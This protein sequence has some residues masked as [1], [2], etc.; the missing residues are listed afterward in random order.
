MNKAGIHVWEV[1]EITLQAEKEYTNCYTEVIVWVDLEGPGFGKQVFGYWD[2]GN[3]FKIRVTATAPGLWSYT[4]GSNADDPGL[5]G[6]MG[7]FTAQA[8]TEDE[9]LENPTRRGIVIP[10]ENGHALQ[11]S[12][13][14][15]FVMVGDTWWA[16]A[17]Y[18]YRWE[19]DEIERTGAEMSMKDMARHRRAQGFNTFGM[20]A[21]FP[22]WAN[23]G[24]STMIKIDDKHQTNIRAAWPQGDIFRDLSGKKGGSIG[25]TAMPLIS[26]KDMHNSGGRPFLFPGNIVGY[27][28]IVPDYDRINPEY[29]KE[30]DKKI[31]WLNANGFTIFIEATRR[32]CT[33]L[34]KNYCDWPMVYTRFIQYIFARYQANNCMFSPIHFDVKSASLDSRDFNEPANLFIDIYGHPPFGTTMGTNAPGSTRIAYGGPDEQRWLTCEQIGNLREHEYF[35]YLTDIFN[36]EPARPAINGEPYYS[37]HICITLDEEDNFKNVLVGDVYHEDD[38][39]NSRSS[40]FGSAL[41]GAFGGV[42]AAFEGMWSGNV[43]EVEGPYKV[44]ETMDFP[45]CSQVRYF[46]DFLLSEGSKYRDLIPNSELVT[47]NKNGDHLGWR[48]WAFCAASKHRDLIMGF[49]EKG[50]KKLKVRCLRPYDKY[51]FAWFNPRTGEWLDSIELMVTRIGNIIVPDYPDDLD[52]AFKLVKTY[53]GQPSDDVVMRESSGWQAWKIRKITDNQ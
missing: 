47:P 3:T 8:W 24:K 53:H 30:L 18:R 7:S 34:F 19:D 50:C 42:L 45:V 9:K 32:D 44:W 41:S 16:L 2:G 23:D 15:P 1:Y 22:T 52:W 33:E 28:D 31:D 4:S 40:Y 11:Y 36:T 25:E 12:D 27:E 20:I 17:T 39:L 37:G 38:H 13:G 35:W 46:R 48:G 49:A 5:R 14:T 43:E 10:T 6:K 51:S 21:A 29:F 26:A